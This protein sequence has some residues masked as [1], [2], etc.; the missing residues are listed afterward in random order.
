MNGKL[1]SKET[2]ISI[3]VCVC[4]K[5]RRKGRKKREKSKMKIEQKIHGL[6][7]IISFFLSMLPIRWRVIRHFMQRVTG[8][9]HMLDELD[10]FFQTG[11]FARLFGI[12]FYEVILRGECTR[13]RKRK[14]KIDK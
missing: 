13:E 2:G 7:I 1:K 3:S 5:K 12:L 8:T 11:E 14:Q 6:L 4:V 9:I 10:F